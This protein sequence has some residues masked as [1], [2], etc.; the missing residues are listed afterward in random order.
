MLN[1]KDGYADN[2]VVRLSLN[3]LNFNANIKALSQELG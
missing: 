3:I 2:S 1:V